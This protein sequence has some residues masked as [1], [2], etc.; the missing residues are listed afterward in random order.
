MNYRHAYHA[1][2]F[3]DV[4][5]HVDA[6]AGHRVPEA[7]GCAVSRHRYACRRG[8]YALGSVE[9][10]QDR[11]VA[12]RHRPP[13]RAR[14]R[15]AAGRCRAGC[16]RPTSMRC[17]PRTLRGR[18]TRLSRQPAHCAAPHAQPRT[19]SSPTS[20]IRRTQ[21]SLKAAIGRDREGQAAGSRRLGGA[22][23]AAAAQGTA[24]RRADRS[25]VRGA[26]ASSHAWPTVWRRLCAASR[27][28][29]IWP[30]TPSRTASPSPRFHKAL[31]ALD[32]WPELLCVELMI[33]GRSSSRP[34]QWLRADCRQ[35]ALCA[36]EHSSQACCPS[37]RAGLAL[38]RGRSPSPRAHRRQG[39]R[40]CADGRPLRIER[41][42][43]AGS[44]RTRRALI[45][46]A[47]LTA[48]IDTRAQFGRPIGP[49]RRLQ[50]L[51]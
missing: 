3:A 24:R 36:A 12:R 14:C 25:S 19:C 31:A 8:R 33:R 26:R 23:V 13:D 17:G 40:R 43:R 35:P 4:L 11:R 47:Q 37:C 50:R 20:S 28:A 22:E 16:W 49:D 29:C 21:A 41:K 48:I 46:L 51:S 34:P 42:A 2:N 6:G 44:P 5:K 18:L 9:A 27:P 15:A 1:G 45:C 32:G 30:G 39:R 38:G 10:G 7:Q